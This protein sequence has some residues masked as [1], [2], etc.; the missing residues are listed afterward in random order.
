MIKTI[1]TY[2]EWFAE[3]K[4]L[5]GLDTMNWKFEC[6]SCG[7]V[8]SVKEWVD[9]GASDGEIAFSCIGRHVSGAQQ[10]FLHRG[11]PCNYAGGGLFAINPVQVRFPDGEV[12]KVFRFAEVSHAT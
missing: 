1:F 6:P 11:G 4:R 5:F 2:E 9:V 8:A 3:G 7:Y 10:A 12:T